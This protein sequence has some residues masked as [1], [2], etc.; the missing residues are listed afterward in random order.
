M[1]R[2]R[3]DIDQRQFENLCGLMCTEEEIASFFGCSIDTVNRWS[4][5]TY[6]LSFAEI[7]KIKSA[8]GKISLRRHQMKLAEKYPAMAIWLGKQMLNQKENIEI[9]SE[10]TLRRLDEVL[11]SIKGVE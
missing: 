1:A 11:A 9:D 5:R 8:Y 10:E 3:I 6:D 4:K 7:Y 2:P